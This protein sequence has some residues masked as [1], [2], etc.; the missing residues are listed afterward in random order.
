MRERFIIRMKNAP[1]T[2]ALAALNE[3]FSDIIIEGKI[4][5]AKPVPEEIEDADKLELARISFNFNRKNYGR[6]RQLI[7]AL[8]GL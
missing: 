3:D 6:L 2:S 1:S 4:E 5:I 7:D 8:N